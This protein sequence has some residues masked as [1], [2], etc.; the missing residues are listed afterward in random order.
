M[1]W[2]CNINERLYA[3]LT[4]KVRIIN[5]TNFH[6]LIFVFC[7]ASHFTNIFL[8]WGFFSVVQSFFMSSNLRR[9]VQTVQTAT[10]TNE[11]AGVFL[12]RVFGHGMHNRTDP[13]LMLDDFRS[14]KPEDFL[15]GFPMHPHRGIET[16]TYVTRG[17]VKHADSIGNSGTIG[18]G[19]IQWM[20][21][22]SGIIHEEMPLGDSEGKMWGFQLWV[23][24]PASQ[25]MCTPKYRSILAKDIPIVSTSGAIVKVIAGQ[26]EGVKGP[27]E[28][29]YAEPVYLDVTVP[30]GKI[31]TYALPNDHICIAYCFEGTGDFAPGVK[32]ANR[33]LAMYEEK[34]GYVQ[35]EANQEGVRFLLLA[36]KPLREPIAWGGPIVMNTQS[37][38]R[39][40]FKELDNDT[41]LQHN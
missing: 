30:A 37:E 14:D 4:L 21:A 39:L 23:N 35:V 18:P 36:G 25:K 38:L 15:Q 31:F 13:F 12:H 28:G 41:F 40:A 2:S 16:V 19:D 17:V 22:G 29:V 33:Q 10:P 3:C 8:C 26:I 9:G 1:K 5:S 32:L 20:T 6:K 7:F 24:L 34:G 11:G 27:V